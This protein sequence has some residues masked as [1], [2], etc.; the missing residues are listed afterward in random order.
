MS[1]VEV[2]ANCK[3]RLSESPIHIRKDNMLYWRGLDG[4]IFRKRYNTDIYD[5]EIFNLNIGNISS[6]LEQEDYLIVF[7]DNGCVYK[8]SAYEEPILLRKY[9]VGLFN[10]C[11]VDSLGRIYCGILADNYFVPGMRGKDCLFTRIDLNGEMT[12]IEKL[13]YTTPNGIAF[14]PDNTKLYF[15]VTDADAVFVYDYNADS[16]EV[17]NRRIFSENCFPDGITIDDSGN[18][19]VTDCRTVGSTLK[20][21][22]ESGELI[23][24]YELP[25]R[26]VISVTFG[27]DKNDILFIT[28]AHEGCPKGEYDGGVFMLKNVGTATSKYYSKIRW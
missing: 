10:D 5:F 13:P 1:N 22:S 16:G 2:F 15:A 18:L 23:R 12:V 25:V 14:S 17:S 27:G 6:I 4:E 26:R 21:F 9:P 8:W 3:P 19:W 20:C 24:T 7:A 11:I 28:T